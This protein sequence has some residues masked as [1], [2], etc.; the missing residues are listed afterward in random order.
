MVDVE[1]YRG[2]VAHD[3]HH[4]QVARDVVVDVA[5]EGRHL[6]AEAGEFDALQLSGKVAGILQDAAE[7]DVRSF[8]G[9]FCGTPRRSGCNSRYE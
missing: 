9:E 3:F 5:E 6:V 1:R 7:N 8:G 4:V 2:D